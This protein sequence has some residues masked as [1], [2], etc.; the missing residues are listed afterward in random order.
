M[1]K[2]TIEPSTVQSRGESGGRVKK[3]AWVRFDD[4][5]WCGTNGNQRLAFRNHMLRASEPF[6]KP[7]WLDKSLK[8]AKAIQRN[9]WRGKALS[10]MLLAD[11]KEGARTKQKG[12]KTANL[13]FGCSIRLFPMGDVWLVRIADDGGSEGFLTLKAS[14]SSRETEEVTKTAP[15][16]FFFSFLAYL[17][18]IVASTTST[19]TTSYS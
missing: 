7:T 8:S 18:V 17:V 19:S 9:E 4:I 10:F 3:C 12:N 11:T 1:Q 6:K 2:M 5:L 13:C 16:V 15:I 14:C